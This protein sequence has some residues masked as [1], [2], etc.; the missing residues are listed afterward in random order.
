[1]NLR[2]RTLSYL[3]VQYRIN[4]F[5]LDS[6]IRCP[7]GVRSASPE[8]SNASID[9]RQLLDPPKYLD[10]YFA[11]RPGTYRF[12]LYREHVR[13]TNT[14]YKYHCHRCQHQSNPCHQRVLCQRLGV[15]LERPVRHQK[16]HHVPLGPIPT[17]RSNRLL[18]HQRYLQCR[19]VMDL[20]HRLQR[21]ARRRRRVSPSH[22]NRF[23]RLCLH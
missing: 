15:Y 10:L 6:S 14:Q 21:S 2:P 4:I 13:T 3:V 1:M 18:H 19:H 9:G 7:H 5:L 20:P 11:R 8:S 22:R 17:R 23:P 12:H 16:N